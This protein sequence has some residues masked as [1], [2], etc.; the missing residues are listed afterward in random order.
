MNNHYD[1]SKSAKADLEDIWNYSENRWGRHQA[2]K[3]YR[4]IIRC[5]VDLS[6]KK[7]TGKPFSE[8]P[9]YFKIRQEHHYIFYILSDNERL[10]VSRI[11]HESMDLPSRLDEAV[12]A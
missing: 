3:Y 2:D 11:L 4:A 7:K 9:K 6:T 10:F 5:I 8:R 1:L 12:M